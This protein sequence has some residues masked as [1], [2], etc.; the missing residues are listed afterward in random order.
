VQDEHN[1]D[2]QDNDE[3]LFGFVKQSDDV[4][5]FVCVYVLP[6]ELCKEETRE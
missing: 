2:E 1:D 5:E 6:C 3:G 4:E